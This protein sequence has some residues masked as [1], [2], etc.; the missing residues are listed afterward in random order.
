[1]TVDPCRVFPG[2]IELGKLG[3]LGKLF[4]DWAECHLRRSRAK[5]L[6][7]LNLWGVRESRSFTV[8]FGG[9]GP[10]PL[11]ATHFEGTRPFASGEGEGVTPCP[12]RPSP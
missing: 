6:K 10:H 2:G 4:R 3:K 12:A 9:K 5:G 8:T 1:V 11:P 7:S